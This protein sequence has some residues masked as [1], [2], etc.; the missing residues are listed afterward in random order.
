[1]IMVLDYG[2][3]GNNNRVIIVMS[4]IN[5]SESNNNHANRATANGKDRSIDR[6]IDLYCKIQLSECN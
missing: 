4:P 2:N 3:D 6:S 1:M 5:K